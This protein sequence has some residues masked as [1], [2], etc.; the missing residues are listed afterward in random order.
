MLYLRRRELFTLIGGAAA[1]GPRMA[2]AQQ[3]ESLRRI[4][5]GGG[6]QFFK[7]VRD[8]GA[9]GNGGVDDT[10]AIQ[11]AIDWTTTNGGRGVIYFP[12]GKYRITRPISLENPRGMAH[13]AITL[14]GDGGNVSDT[15]SGTVIFGNFPDFLIKKAK[16]F[17]SSA[18]KIMEGLTLVNSNSSGGC[19]FISGSAHA[20]VRDCGIQSQCYG[21]MFDQM[22]APCIVSNCSFRAH[23][24][25]FNSVGLH[26]GGT[27]GL[28]IGNDFVGWDEGVRFSLG[29]N[30]VLSSRLELNRKAIQVGA[31]CQRQQALATS[32]NGAGKV[33][34]T[35]TSTAMD[36]TGEVLSFQN[37][38]GTPALN[39][40]HPVVVIDA[41]H[42]DVPEV[43]FVAADS[44]VIIGGIQGPVTGATGYSISGNTFEGN[45]Y[46]VYLSGGTGT[47]ANNAIL[48]HDQGPSGQSIAGIYFDGGLCNGIENNAINGGYSLGPIYQ[49]STRAVWATRLG[50]NALSQANP[51]SGTYTDTIGPFTLKSAVGRPEWLVAGLKVTG[52]GVPVNATLASVGENTFTLSAAI[53]GTVTTGAAFQFFD[54]R[55][56]FQ[57]GLLHF[58]TPAGD[59]T[60]GVGNRTMVTVSGSLT[61]TQYSTIE[62]DPAGGTLQFTIP[63]DASF[64]SQGHGSEYLLIQ[65][66]AGTVNI[67][68]GA[69]ATVRGLTSVGGRD[70]VAHLRYT[71]SNTWVVY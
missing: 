13:I 56:G 18:V 21:V 2:Q 51:I 11:A 17:Q 60:S 37:A 14:K 61:P 10:A 3:P 29:G 45:D 15:N 30:S 24:S 67:V 71:T 33:R 36:Y 64:G 35:V 63:S 65:S 66:G 6:L 39:G 1:G 41:T 59:N 57:V 43:D 5:P 52:P 20:S 48:G 9:T 44:G 40:T 26:L 62:F 31:S 12:L 19:V 38:V 27:G 34:L 16:G 46:G 8:F 4:G 47:I 53:S 58:G 28:C 23:R 55:N 32:N 68:A 42:F 22:N 54:P 25:P 50:F 70:K 7:N 49:P 69:G